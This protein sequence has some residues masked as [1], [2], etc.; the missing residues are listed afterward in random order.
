MTN[1]V[2]RK[3]SRN[4][5][6]GEHSEVKVSTRLHNTHSYNQFNQILTIWDITIVNLVGAINSLSYSKILSTPSSHSVFLNGILVLCLT[7]TLK[8]NQ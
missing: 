5:L 1:Q 8:G 2:I 7:A 4:H 6:Y 3:N